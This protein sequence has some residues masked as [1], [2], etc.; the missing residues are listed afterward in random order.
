MNLQWNVRSKEKIARTRPR[1]ATVAKFRLSVIEPDAVR[2]LGQEV[3]E[4]FMATSLDR[5]QIPY[6]SRNREIGCSG[7][8]SSLSPF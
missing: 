3:V 5:I 6:A 1:C 8:L 4:Y 2:D 7:V